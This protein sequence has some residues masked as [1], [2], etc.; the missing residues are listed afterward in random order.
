MSNPLPK[1][2]VPASP[3]GPTGGP[4]DA[5]NQVSSTTQLDEPVQTASARYARRVQAVVET[6]MAYY[7]RGEVQQYDSLTLTNAIDRR[8]MADGI[9]INRAT[10]HVSPEDATWDSISYFVCSTFPYNIYYDVF[11]FKIGGNEFSCSCRRMLDTCNDYCVYHYFENCGETVEEAV[12]NAK[13]ILRPGD[14][15]VGMKEVKQGEAGHAMIYLGDCLD[16]GHNYVAHSWGGKYNMDTCVERHEKDGTIVLQDAFDC[17]FNPKLKT[18]PRW[19]LYTMKEFSIVRPLCRI[20]DEN[21]P[22]TTNALARLAHPGLNI[23]RRTNITFYNTISAGSPITYTITVENQSSQDYAAL[24]VEEILPE[25]TSLV[26]AEGAVQNGNRISWQLDIPAGGKATVQY[27]VATDAACSVVISE[28][29]NVA[30]IRSNRIITHLGNVLPPETAARLEEAVKQCKDS[31]SGLAFAGQ[32]YAKLDL[33]LELPVADVLING[34]FEPIEHH[35]ATGPI[36]RQKAADTQ[37]RTAEA[38]LVPK[39]FGG[40]TLITETAAQRILEFDLRYLQP[41]DILLYVTNPLAESQQEDAYLYLGDGTFAF[42]KD[43][44]VQVTK[45]ELIWQAFAKDLFLLLRPSLA[46]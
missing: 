31:C 16:N 10:N 40:K 3:S 33:P 44:N 6:A 43:G 18:G 35:S 25:N 42:C 12:E 24:P 41:G 7:R 29:G 2:P 20:T 37:C 45:D 36:L 32:V 17:L 14:V 23:D 38:M 28:G 22:L 26:S 15:V 19:C 5:M 11:G 9:G 34:M 27:T 1:T 21:Y 39:Y 8:H 4:E 13:R 46:G 30:G